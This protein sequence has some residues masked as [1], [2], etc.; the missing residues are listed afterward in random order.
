MSLSLSCSYDNSK[1]QVVLKRETNVKK[2]N[3]ELP[4]KSLVGNRFLILFRL[5]THVAFLR[6]K[7][8]VS[9]KNTVVHCQ[10]SGNECLVLSTGL[11]RKFG[12]PP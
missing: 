6:Y 9:K 2:I 8:L 4:C 3:S 11:I 7:E 12:S 10:G 1:C 5:L